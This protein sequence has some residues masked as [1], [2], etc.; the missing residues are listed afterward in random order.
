M[1]FVFYILMCSVELCSLSTNTNVHIRRWH[2]MIQCRH[3][4]TEVVVCYSV[5][6]RIVFFSEL[7]AILTEYQIH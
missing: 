2:Y 4:Q 5:R 7:A 1:C 6:E 3:H